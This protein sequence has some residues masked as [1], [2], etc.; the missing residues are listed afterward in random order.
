M[1]DFDATLPLMAIQFVILTAI[2]NALFFKPM[3]KIVEGREGFIRSSKTES[4]ERLEKAQ[5]LTQQYEQELNATRRESQAIIANAQEEAKK[6]SAEQI[7]VAQQQVQEEVM[8]VLQ[9]LESQKQNAMGQLSADADALSQQIL[10]KL[11]GSGLP[12]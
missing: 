1:F 9:E 2:M 10:D 8:K 11:L 6:I 7:A 3:A 4:K 5:Q 12:A